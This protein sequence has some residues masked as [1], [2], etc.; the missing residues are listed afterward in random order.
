MTSESGD[1]DNNEATCT[2]RNS[3]LTVPAWDG[4]TEYHVVLRRQTVWSQLMMN[5]VNHVLGDDSQCDKEDAPGMDRTGTSSSSSTSDYMYDNRRVHNYNYL[6]DAVSCTTQERRSLLL[7]DESESSA[8]SYYSSCS[9]NTSLFSF[10]LPN[11]LLLEADSERLLDQQQQGAH[12]RRQQRRRPG[13]Y[14]P[15]KLTA[16]FANDL[17]A[18]AMGLETAFDSWNLHNSQELSFIGEAPEETGTD[19]TNDEDCGTL[20]STVSLE[21]TTGTGMGTEDSPVEDETSSSCS[22]STYIGMIQEEGNIMETPQTT[23]TNSTCTEPFDD[24]Y[25]E[26]P[27]N[28]PLQEF[29]YYYCIAI[30]D[31]RAK[32]NSVNTNLQPSTRKDG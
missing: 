6:N 26:L 15:D 2:R 4:T 28:N 12:C 13:C 27:F 9:S 29:W 8:L 25:D 19:A 17:E 24:S 22:A 16:R 5:V 1:Q 11:D 14:T 32:H 20:L 23:K 3:L 18:L 30:T 31:L 7:A 10:V 21:S